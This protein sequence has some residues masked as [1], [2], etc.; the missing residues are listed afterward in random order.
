MTLG[1]V[2]N[3]SSRDVEVQ[4]IDLLH[5][6][7]IMKLYILGVLSLAGKA[8]NYPFYSTI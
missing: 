2:D 3:E 7:H 1:Y 6:T 8:F 5:W 4:R